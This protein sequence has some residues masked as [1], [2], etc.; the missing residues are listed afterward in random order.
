MFIL[1]G[2]LNGQDLILFVIFDVFIEVFVDV[3][4]DVFVE[5]LLLVKF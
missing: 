2:T 3:L 5:I 4:E 1:L